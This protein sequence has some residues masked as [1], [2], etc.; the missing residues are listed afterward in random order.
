MTDEGVVGLK[1]DG[2]GV[3]VIAGIRF[4]TGLGLLLG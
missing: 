1:D 4:H 2:Q 3:R